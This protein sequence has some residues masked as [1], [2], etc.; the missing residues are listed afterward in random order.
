MVGLGKSNHTESTFYSSSLYLQKHIVIDLSR[1][2][3]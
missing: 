1:K 3:E 2:I